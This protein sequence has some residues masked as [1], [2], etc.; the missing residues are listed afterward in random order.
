[1][2]IHSKRKPLIP[3]RLIV[4]RHI[5]LVEVTIRKAM[6]IFVISR[7]NNPRFHFTKDKLSIR[8]KY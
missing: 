8:N 7:G 3:T 1:M 4:L 5:G 2:P 6:K